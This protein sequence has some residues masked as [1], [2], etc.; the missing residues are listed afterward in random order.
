[1]RYMVKIVTPVLF[2]IFLSNMVYA[3]CQ[4]P[5][6]IYGDHTRFELLKEH[7][8]TIEKSINEI[9]KLS[10]NPAANMNQL[11]RWVNN[12][13]KHADDFT[14]IVTYYF[15]AQRIK[16]KEA[17]DK[18]EFNDYQMKVTL[19]HQMMVYAMKCK[20]TTDVKNT[21]QLQMLVDQFREIYFT[22][23][24]KSHLKVHQKVK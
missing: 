16:I 19:L 21:Q 14:D 22:E 12:K 1:M 4:V 20:Q 5:C 13:D 15:L 17:K 7:I 10:A 9:N 18:K 23:E 24:Q 3:H 2:L 8:K 11:V 6:G